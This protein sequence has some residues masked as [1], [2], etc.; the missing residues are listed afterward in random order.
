MDSLKDFLG[1]IPPWMYLAIAGFATTFSSKVRDVLFRLASHVVVTDHL[2]ESDTVHV[3]LGWLRAHGR[4]SVFGDR[5]YFTM[6]AYVR[7]KDRRQLVPFVN[8]SFGSQVFWVGAVPV[9]VSLTEKSNGHEEGADAMS[10]VRVRYLRGTLDVPRILFDMTNAMADIDASVSE[11]RYH[12]RRMFGSAK[13]TDNEAPKVAREATRNPRVIT[14][15]AAGYSSI[16]PLGWTQ[17][18]IADRASRI[19]ST[20]V[21]A[22]HLVEVWEEIRFWRES[23]DWFRHRSIPWRRGYLLSGPPGTG[24]T[25][26]VRAVASDLGVPVFSFDL[27]SMNNR[28]LSAAWDEMMGET[29]CVALIEDVDSVFEGRRNLNAN[30]H[31]D[32][33]TFDCLLNCIDGV[34]DASGVLLFITSNHADTLDPAIGAVLEDGRWRPSRPGRIDRVVAFGDLDEVGRREIASRILEGMDASV[35]ED[36]VSQGPCTPAVMQERCFERAI[37]WRMSRHQDGASPQALA[38]AIREPSAPR[39]G[40]SERAYPLSKR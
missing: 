12:V 2:I 24:K 8:L 30:G 36:V 22:A 23:G 9:W 33:L 29:P 25:S 40:L 5:H 34:S 14:R 1:S 13:E 31:R 35:I 39:R 6:R 32:T 10:H 37:A 18:D 26:F 27:A 38:V 4:R 19:S 11:D 15:A 20:L 21:M 28:D 3:I 16:I 17:E 7:S